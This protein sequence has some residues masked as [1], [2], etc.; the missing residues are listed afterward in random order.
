VTQ[1]LE[2]YLEAIYLII[3]KKKVARVKDISEQLSVKKPSVINAV[4]ELEAR[5]MVVHEKYGYIE[6]TPQGEEAAEKI[7]ERHQTIHAFLRDF[8]KVTD[9]VAED[10]ACKIEHHLSPETFDKLKLYMKNNKA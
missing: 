9:E 1:S 6:L 3:Q 4:K 5:N 2:D 8:L 7:Y 10:D